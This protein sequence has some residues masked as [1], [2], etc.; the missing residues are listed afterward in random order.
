MLDKLQYTRF[1]LVTVDRKHLLLVLSFLG[2]IFC[3]AEQNFK[4][5][6]QLLQ[7]SN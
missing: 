6:S 3:K 4:M 1:Y 7:T 5:Q 2:T